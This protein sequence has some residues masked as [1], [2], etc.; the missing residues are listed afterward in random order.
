MQKDLTEEKQRQIMNDFKDNPEV[1]SEIYEFYFDRILKY[2]ARRTSDAELAYDLTADTFMKALRTF[3]RF[4]WKGIS[5]KVWL[6]RIA[7]NTLRDHY[8]RKDRQPIY[9]A[10]IY[11]N[12]GTATS[13]KEELEAIDKNLYGDPKLKRLQ[14]SIEKLN[15][16]YQKVLTL[17]YYT[18]LSHEEISGV[19]GRSRGAVKAMMHRAMT[20]LRAEMKSNTPQ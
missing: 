11:E 13:I 4:S 16:K 1:F 19:M 10:E 5:I 8:R 20:L 6:Y 7:T 9:V 17:Y 3:H 14:R 15:P 18:G 2:L 12:A